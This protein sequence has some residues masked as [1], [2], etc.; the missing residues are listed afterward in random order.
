MRHKERRGR[1][2]RS[3][4]RSAP[5]EYQAYAVGEETVEITLG[6]ACVSSTSCVPLRGADLE[7]AEGLVEVQYRDLADA[8]FSGRRPPFLGLVPCQFRARRAR[9][10]VSWRTVSLASL[11]L[12]TPLSNDPQ[13]LQST[14][15]SETAQGR[16]N[17]KKT[18]QIHA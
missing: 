1:N 3:Q 8:R 17:A 18:K 16:L 7:L 12:D 5:T 6:P 2:N 11:T 13:A 10:P 9:D 15:R 14:L 4:S